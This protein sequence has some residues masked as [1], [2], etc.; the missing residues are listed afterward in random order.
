MPGSIYSYSIL[1]FILLLSF[2]QGST[3]L[4]RT[5]E[6]WIKVWGREA[7]DTHWKLMQ[8]GTHIR[9]LREPEK[10]FLVAQGAER[11]RESTTWSTIGLYGMSGM[12][13]VTEGWPKKGFCRDRYGMHKATEVSSSPTD[14][15]KDLMFIEHKGGGE[16]AGPW[17]QELMRWGGVW[18]WRG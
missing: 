15:E 17:S 10:G 5:K 8:D 9:R 2:H 7:R 16:G 1:S 6:D 18:W 13:Q 12:S 4:E 11:I 14:T 3:K